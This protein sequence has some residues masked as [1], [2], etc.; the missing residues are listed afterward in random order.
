[1]TREDKQSALQRIAERKMALQATMAE[2]DAHAAK[3]MKM[4]LTF[5]EEYPEEYVSYE[6]A[7]EEYNTLEVEGNIIATTE[8]E[9]DEM[10]WRDPAGEEVRDEGL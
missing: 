5:R 9:D 8:V 6:A 1:M 2:S 4:G 10:R 3:C 7:R